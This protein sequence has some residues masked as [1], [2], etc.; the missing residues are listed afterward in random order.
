MDTDTLRMPT[1]D[2]EDTPTRWAVRLALM[3]ARI[4]D[5]KNT[6]S[7]CLGYADQLT[8]SLHL[9]RARMDKFAS[10]AGV[11][12]SPP[13]PVITDPLDMP[14]TEAVFYTETPLWQLTKRQDGAGYNIPDTGFDLLWVGGK[15]QLLL[16]KSYG[17]SVVCE[18]TTHRHLLKVLDEHAKPRLVGDGEFDPGLVA[19]AIGNPVTLPMAGKTFYEI[20]GCPLK[21]LDRAH[22]LHVIETPDFP[23]A[24]RKGVLA[25]L[26]KQT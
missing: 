22:L 16:R 24:I 10:D 11:A 26:S 14:L 4:G 7:W 17:G 6:M 8:T 19:R 12:D 9:V 20:G 13:A 3:E 25:A 15:S 2:D 23:S 5:L 21:R 18:V 1:A